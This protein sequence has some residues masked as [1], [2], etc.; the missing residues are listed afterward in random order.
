M[1]VPLSYFF[2]WNSVPENMRDSFINEFKEHGVDNFVLTSTPLEGF[3]REPSSFGSWLRLK[4]RHNITF[5]DAHM[6]YSEHMDLSCADKGRFAKKIEEQK[7][8]MG[9]AADLGCKTCTIHVGAFESVFLKTPIEKIRPTVMKS[10]EM[11]LPE[12][13][14]LGIML[15]IENSFE[16]TNAP[17]EIISYIKS[18]PSENFGVC[19]DSGHA[20]LMEYFPGKEFRKFYPGVT[21]AWEEDAVG[22]CN[23]ALD[24]LL[25]HIV[26][27][28]LHDND[29]YIDSHMMPGDGI[30]DWNKLMNK[31][32]N[33]P[34]L[35]TLQ[36]EVIMFKYGY[37]VKRL[38]DTFNKLMSI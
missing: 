12:A 35:M 9:Y 19:F 34:R 13:E 25:P 10:I 21:E 2:D 20:N 3:L 14:K 4:K 32:K 18:F 26:T 8:A 16:K 7:A 28:H 24:Q 27:C 1:S 5:S 38:V 29:G 6:P 33:A 23:D 36:T 37:P 22:Y 11:L 30:I 15:L 31:L 17:S